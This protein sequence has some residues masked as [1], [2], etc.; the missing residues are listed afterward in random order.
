MDDNRQSRLRIASQAL[1]FGLDGLAF[2][3]YEPMLQN[4]SEDGEAVRGMVE[5]Y[6]RTG[7]YKRSLTMVESWMARHPDDPVMNRK[8]NELSRLAGETASE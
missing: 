1:M 7:D 2:S 6:Q 8:R 4:N 5:Y 3:I